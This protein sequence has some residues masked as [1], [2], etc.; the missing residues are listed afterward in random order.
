M[1][2]TKKYSLRTTNT[3]DEWSAEIVRRV[4]SSRTVVSKSQA[5][6]ASE[7]DAQSWGEKELASFLQNL[8]ERNKRHSEQRENK[9]D[10]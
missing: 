2:K 5:G 8:N 4:S 9:T 3:N 10:K 1:S 7:A 6:F